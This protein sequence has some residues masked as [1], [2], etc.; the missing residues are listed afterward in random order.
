M[1][2]AGGPIRSSGPVTPQVTTTHISQQQVWWKPR[3]LTWNV[4]IYISIYLKKKILIIW[5]RAQLFNR[6]HKSRFTGYLTKVHQLWAESQSHLRWQSEPP[7]TL[8]SFTSLSDE[9][10]VKSK[11]IW[12]VNKEP[13][14]ELLAYQCLPASG[15]ATPLAE[16]DCE[17][18][19]SC[20][21]SVLCLPSE[22]VC[23]LRL[24]LPKQMSLC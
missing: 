11:T 17:C 12:C 2:P 4:I 21:Q 3:R 20:R 9:Q 18:P 24:L 7:K 23:S 6:I 1:W 16:C 15:L 8:V 19:P 10:Q 13:S 22:N 5:P 14:E